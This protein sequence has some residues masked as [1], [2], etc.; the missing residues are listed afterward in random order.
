MGIYNIL[1]LYLT[2]GEFIINMDLNFMGEPKVVILVLENIN[3]L[4]QISS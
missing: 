4:R 1:V 3:S 2:I